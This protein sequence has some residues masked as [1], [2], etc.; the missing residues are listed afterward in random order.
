MPLRAT[1]LALAGFAVLSA[2]AIWTL[3]AWLSRRR[4]LSLTSGGT[5]A[6]VDTDIFGSGTTL[7]D[8]KLGICGK[9]DYVLEGSADGHRVLMPLE[10]KPSRHSTRLYDSD[11]VQIAAY[12]IALRGTFPRLASRVGYVQYADRTFDVVLTPTLEDEITRLVAALR[13]GR[14]A[15]VMRRSHNVPA[16]CRA[17]PVRQ[18]CDERLI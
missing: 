13:R 5:F 2:I 3:R 6:V 4:G 10:V 14:S 18:R 8:P 9:P 1:L 15:P 7:R 11:R 17:C 16:K 12:L